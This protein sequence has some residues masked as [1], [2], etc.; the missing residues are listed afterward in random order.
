MS[1]SSRCGYA[2]ELAARRAKDHFRLEGGVGAPKHVLMCWI[3]NVPAIAE[4]DRK[5]SHQTSQ[6][7]QERKSSR[8][9]EELPNLPL[10]SM[11]LGFLE[12]CRKGV[13]RHDSAIGVAVEFLWHG[14]VVLLELLLIFL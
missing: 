5:T 3:A 8:A 7:A 11:S 4:V 9:G 6:C 13:W 14:L 10:D 1:I 2:P 12:P